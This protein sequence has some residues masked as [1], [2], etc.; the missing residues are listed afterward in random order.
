MAIRCY[1]Q[2]WGP[3]QGAGALFGRGQGPVRSR[4]CTGDDD[5]NP[6]HTY[7][8]CGWGLTMSDV[9]MYTSTWLGI[10]Q[11][12]ILFGTKFR[13][14]TTVSRSRDYCL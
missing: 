10:S 2:R 14:L 7:S 8:N 6:S 11:V 4:A 3:V 12:F 9:Y 13:C 1:Y 5:F